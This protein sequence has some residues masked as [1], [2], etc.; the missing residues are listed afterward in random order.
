MDIKVNVL[1]DIEHEVEVSLS[2]EEI[3]PEI[4][5]AYSEERK[6]I[7]LPGF[8]KGK[9]PVSMLKKVYGDA[10]E[11]KASE[12][13]ANKKFWE[14]VEQ[15]KLEPVN[16][17]ELVDINFVKDE[18]LSFKVKYEV[19]PEIEVKDYTGL[20]VEKPVFKTKDEDVE[21][22][23]DHILKSQAQYEEAEKIED[24]NTKITVDLQGLDKDGV[25]MVGSRSENMAI[26]LADPNVNPVI[27]EAAMGKGVEDKFN[28]DFEDPTKP[29]DA[30]HKY[31]YEATI[32][33]IEKAVPP[34]MNEEFIKKVSQ[35][36]AKTEDELKDLIR[37]NYEKY[38]KDQSEQIYLNG[39]LGKIV[40][41]NEV[42]APSG[43]VESIQKRM[44]EMEKENAKRQGMTNVDENALA[45]KIKPRAEWNAKWQIVMEAIAK[46]EEIVINDADIEELAKKEAENTGISVDKLVKYLKDSK[47]DELL[48]EEKVINFLKEKNVAKEVD[49]EEKQKENQKAKEE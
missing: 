35:D 12:T 43:F 8:R 6:E 1:S 38:F 2:Y 46:K 49:A 21:R 3:K 48:L 31:Y 28:F 25:P 11:H 22:E 26:N 23:I 5:E 15:E 41:N 44:V 39:L 30:P 33:K 4:D 13:I 37:E 16:T 7:S 14:V 29:E 10:I 32:N 40:E 18:T 24:E 9:V 47:R 45:E 17:P 34:E 20:E 27:K 19:K 36:K 42:T